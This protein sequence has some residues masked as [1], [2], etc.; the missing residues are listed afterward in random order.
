MSPLDLRDLPL[1][2]YFFVL[3]PPERPHR[4][5]EDAVV[6]AVKSLSLPVAETVGSACWP[7]PDRRPTER[8]E[9]R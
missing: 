8:N 3:A 6:E 4:S 7:S 5:L 2:A 1:S 9:Q